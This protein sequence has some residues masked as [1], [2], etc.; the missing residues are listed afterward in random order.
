MK[1]AIQLLSQP[2]LFF[3]N[4]ATPRDKKSHKDRQKPHNRGSISN[5]EP[6]K[7]RLSPRVGLLS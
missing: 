1:F 2:L 3:M 5:T 6:K 4:M 7:K